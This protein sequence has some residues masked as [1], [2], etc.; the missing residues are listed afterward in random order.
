M[1]DYENLRKYARTKRQHEVLDALEEAGSQRKAALVLGVGRGAVECA[2]DSMR[3]RAVMQS[4]SPEHDMTHPLPPPLMLKRLSTNYDGETGKVNQQWVIGEPDKEAQIQAVLRAIENSLGNVKPLKKIAKPKHR[5]DE[6]LLTL[7]T[8][9]DFH[10]GMYAWHEETGADWDVDIAEAVMF[11]SLR[12]MMSASP[13][14]QTAILNLQ[15]DFLHWDGLEAITPTSK[16]ILDADTRFDKLADLSIQLTQ[17]AILELLGKHQKVKLVVC[18]GNHDMAG[19]VWLR[20]SMKYLFAN[21]PRVDVDDTPVPFYAHLHG[22]TLLCFHHGH[23]V[24]NKS[25][26]EL[27][28]SEPKFRPDWGKATYTYIHTGHYHKQEQDVSEFGGAIVERHPTLAARDA[29]AAR[30]G[31]VSYRGAHA[32]TYSDTEGEISRYTTRPKV[33]SE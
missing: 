19:S 11:G 27:F 20:K 33:S 7:Y 10:L 30:G 26:P 2:L 13:D 5:Q 25:L 29:Y 15:G 8:L 21:N 1:S 24:K 17:R 18:E 4:D 28:S 14:S 16:N 31:W 6:S 12:D 32:I 22:Q 3:H 23:K 9:T